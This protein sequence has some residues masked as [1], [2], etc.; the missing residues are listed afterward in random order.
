MTIEK[1]TIAYMVGADLYASGRDYDLGLLLGELTETYND[2]YGAGRWLAA[3]TTDLP[4]DFSTDTYTIEGGQLVKASPEL[5]AERQAAKAK[6]AASVEI[7]QLRAYLT[8]TDYA[9]IK[10]G[11]LGLSMAEIYP[12]LH[13][14]RTA[15]RARINELQE[16][17]AE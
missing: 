13:A 6:A 17:G 14:E 5:I 9:P 10:C 16:G 1:L 2:I 15:A 7:A 11:E 12:E 4:A 8:Q 3:P